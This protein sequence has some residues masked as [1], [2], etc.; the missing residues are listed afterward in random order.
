MRKNYRNN[1]K[2]L[3]TDTDSWKYEAKCQDIYADMKEDMEKNIQEYD[4]SDYPQ[5]NLFGCRKGTRKLWVWWTANL[6]VK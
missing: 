3:Y 4:I 2:L 5:E 6:M 1:C